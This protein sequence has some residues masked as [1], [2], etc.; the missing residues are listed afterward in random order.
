MRTFFGHNANTVL[1]YYDSD[2]N[3]QSAQESVY[4]SDREAILNNLCHPSNSV[5]TCAP[6]PNDATVQESVVGLDDDNLT[7]RGTWQFFTIA[8]CY[9]QEFE[10]STGSYFYVPDEVQD[11]SNLTIENGEKCFY[12][13]TNPDALST[14]NGD[15]IGTFIPGLNLSRTN[16]ETNV[17]I[18]SVNSNKKKR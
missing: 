11:P 13:N 17:S 18:P 12:T 15:A 16:T 14:L 10:D 5:I 2:D 9:M 4:A 6:C 3:I 1:S 8:D 7:V